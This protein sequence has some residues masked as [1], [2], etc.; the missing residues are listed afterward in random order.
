GGAHA[1]GVVHRDL[2]PENVLFAADGRPLVADLGL[3]KHFHRVESSISLSLSGAA[4]G[5]AG[6][7]APE[8]MEDAKAVG[9][10]ADVFALGAIL[11]ECLAGRP[12][13]AGATLV[14]VVSKACDSRIEPLSAVAPGTPAWLAS[15][16][17]RALACAPE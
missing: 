12:T 13:F 11:Y 7:M 2:K 16:V 15:L 17:E 5:T 4:R 1:R 10:P 14:E 6:Y 8:Q 3:A 9:P